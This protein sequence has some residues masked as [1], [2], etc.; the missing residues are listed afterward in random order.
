MLIIQGYAKY[1]R[2][3]KAWLEQ[4]PSIADCIEIEGMEDRGVTGNFE[5][6]IGEDRRLI[7][8]KRTAGQ[9]RAESCKERAMIVES[10]QEY[11]DENM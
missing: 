9:G 7:H 11:I 5:V 10:I 2:G 6:R 4:Q 8:S 3:L 1:Y